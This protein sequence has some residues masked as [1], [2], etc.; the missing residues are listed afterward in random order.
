MGNSINSFFPLRSPWYKKE[1]IATSSTR[2]VGGRREE[3][4]KER[5][6]NRHLPLEKIFNQRGGGPSFRLDQNCSD[7]FLRL[8]LASFWRL[9]QQSPHCPSPLRHFV[10][11]IRRQGGRER[12]Q[13]SSS[14][15]GES[16]ITAEKSLCGNLPVPTFPFPVMKLPLNRRL[17]A[18][19]TR[20]IDSLF[21]LAREK[22]LF[23]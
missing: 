9:Q 5:R 10:R 8:N 7:I 4:K 15:E 17:D 12:E 20:N 14:T 16:L 23:E 21:Q 22:R 11:D 13:S 6:K 18:L 3:K 2:S 1:L 19:R